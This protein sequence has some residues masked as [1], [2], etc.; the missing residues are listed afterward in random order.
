MCLLDNDSPMRGKAVPRALRLA[1][2]LFCLAGPVAAENL[3]VDAQ[4]NFDKGEYHA[5]IIDT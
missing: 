1:A 5:E 3:L 4:R 2:C